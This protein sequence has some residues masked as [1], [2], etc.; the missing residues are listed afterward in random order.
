MRSFLKLAF[1]GVFLAGAA[2]AQE[3]PAGDPAR[4]ETLVGKCRTCHGSDG[5]AK[6]VVAPHIAGE[7]EAYLAA[8]L[9]AFRDGARRN[10]MMSVVV[11]DLSDQDIADLAAWYAS[12]PVV[13]NFADDP[14]GAPELCVACHGEAGIAEQDDTP[15]LAGD[16][17]MY[18]DAQLNAFR[19]G[20]RESEVM[21][22]IA[23]DLTDADIKAAVDW[24]TRV[25]LNVE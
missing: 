10:E 9:A 16:S 24:Y 4:G 23:A 7:P 6:L 11:K 5:I 18:L 22:V 3:F 2:V 14:G 8:Q 1:G 17:A 19:D 13:A 25:Q 20:S 21:N 12:H 15:H